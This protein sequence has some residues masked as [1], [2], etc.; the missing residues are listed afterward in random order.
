MSDLRR[1]RAGRA[2][3]ARQVNSGPSSAPIW[4]SAARCRLVDARDR[5]RHH[6]PLRGDTTRMAGKLGFDASL[7]RGSRPGP[8]RDTGRAGTITEAEASRLMTLTNLAHEFAEIV[9]AEQI[10]AAPSA[11]AREEPRHHMPSWCDDA[12]A[13]HRKLTAAN[14]SRP[15]REFVPVSGAGPQHA[16][17][18]RCRVASPSSASRAASR[19]GRR[20]V[21]ASLARAGGRV[22]H[23]A[24]RA[25]CVLIDNAGE[26]PLLAR[27]TRRLQGRRMA[28]ATRSST[29]HRHRALPWSR[30]ARGVR[31]D[32]AHYP[33][34]RLVTN[35]DA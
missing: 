19:T 2:C 27:R 35:K 26:Q 13:R 32:A 22:R 33:D 30:S 16:Q 5:R 1:A 10:I 17:P 3:R 28:M 11:R 25:T 4:S 14:G 12:E 34:Y 6:Q 18:R 8:S 21:A 29:V 20:V 31:S 7:C 23:G 24:D 9:T 15:S